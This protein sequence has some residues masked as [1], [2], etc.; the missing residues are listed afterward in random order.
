MIRIFAND[1]V[2]SLDMYTIEN[3][4][5]ASS[6][7]VEEAAM[8]FVKEFCLHYSKISRIIVFAGQ[9]KNG[10]DALAIARM[11]NDE[12]YKVI[13]YLINPTNYL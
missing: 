12:S 4:P 1:Q 7:L 2:K 3:K 10:A 9:G 8:A 13:T 5:I 6:D 11:L